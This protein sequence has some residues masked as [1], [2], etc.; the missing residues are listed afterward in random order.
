MTS[1]QEQQDVLAFNKKFNVPMSP[2]P[3]LLCDELFRYRFQFLCEEL[4]EFKSACYVSDLC[5]AA[6]ALIDLVYVAHGT[7]LMMGLPWEQLWAEVQKKN[8]L[9]IATRRKEDSKRGSV[10]DVTKPDDWTPPDHKSILGPG[11]YRVFDP[12]TDPHTDPHGGR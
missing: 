3:A 7:A 5:D 10:Y 9:K 2:V 11:P 6:D 1:S 12:H 4:M 8:M